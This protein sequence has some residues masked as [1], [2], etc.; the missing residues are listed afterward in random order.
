MNVILAVNN[1][2]IERFIGS[3]PT[4]TVLT[5][6]RRREQVIDSVLSRNPNTIVLSPALGGRVDMREIISTLKK[7]KPS[8]KIVYIYGDRD[9]EY[10]GFLDF[11]VRTGVYDFVP[12]EIT[13]DTIKAA[14]LKNSSLNDVRR[15]LLDED[16]AARLTAEK[17]KKALN[18]DAAPIIT[19]PV[20]P[21]RLDV[22]IVEKVYERTKIQNTFLG[23]VTIGIGSLFP[24]A[25]CTHTSLEMAATLRHQKYDVGVCTD[26][27]TFKKLRDYYLLSDGEHTINGCDIY[28]D[29]LLAKQRHKIV[30]YDLGHL[31]TADQLHRFYDMG[32]AVLLC[33]AAPWEIDRLTD[34]LRDNEFAQSINFL[35]YP[36]SEKDFKSLSKNMQQGGCRAYRIASNPDIFARSS[37]NAKVYASALRSVLAQLKVK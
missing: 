7:L 33:P 16:D 35:F 10:K 20:K 8:V 18:S 22:L 14:L 21:A 27:D 25:G 19:T 34:F 9:N 31:E 2:T 23:N 17:E 26:A 5:T 13:E 29:E 15:Y 28:C 1:K 32:A 36:I 12:E 4:V 6:I 11:L 3:L 24:R 30:V 37:E